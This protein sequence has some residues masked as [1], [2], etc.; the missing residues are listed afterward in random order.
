VNKIETADFQAAVIESEQLV[1]VDFSATWCG[2]CRM[3]EPVLAQLEEQYAGSVNFVK[4]D[5]DVSGDLASK[6]G[7]VNVPTLVL[8]KGGEPVSR[9]VGLSPKPVLESWIK[10]NSD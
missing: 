7:V 4:V 1:V 3:L 8:F 6:F 9:K 5:I 10:E 2:P